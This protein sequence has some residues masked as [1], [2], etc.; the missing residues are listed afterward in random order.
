MVGS[1]YCC[2]LPHLSALFA[3]ATEVSLKA[4]EFSV[5]CLSAFAK[6]QVEADYPVVGRVGFVGERYFGGVGLVG[7]RHSGRGYG[8]LPRAPVLGP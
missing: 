3:M 8:R 7:E 1:S 4:M 6:D 2:H 5:V